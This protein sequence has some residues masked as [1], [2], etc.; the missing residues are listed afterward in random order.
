MSIDLIIIVVASIAVV[1]LVF[2]SI[3]AFEGARD[4]LDR[5]IG[6]N[7]LHRMTQRRDPPPADTAGPAAALTS[8]EVAY[9]IGV[10]D[11]PVPVTPDIPPPAPSGAAA[12]AAAARAAAASHGMAGTAPTSAVQ[13]PMIGV[14]ERSIES[15]PA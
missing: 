14:S 13:D 11:A 4:V 6:A 2:L 1:G 10:P 7:V 8:D 15:P 12:T 9:R 5:V 3:T